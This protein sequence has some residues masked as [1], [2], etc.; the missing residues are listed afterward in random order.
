GPV[1]VVLADQRDGA[2]EVR[3][4]QRGQR[5]QQ[6]VGQVVLGGGHAPILAAGAHPPALPCHNRRHRQQVPRPCPATATSPAAIPCTAPTTTTSTACRNAR[7]RCC[8]SACCWRS[9]RPDC[10]GR[11]CCASA[12][13][14][15][16]PTTASTWKRSPPTARPTGPACWPIRA[17]CATGSRS[18]RRSTT[19]G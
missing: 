17:S 14:S 7:R 5:D 8:S 19:P 18:G 15:A 9:T 4:G 16:A 1:V 11:P 3:V 12:R 6:V 10:A 13:A 2:G